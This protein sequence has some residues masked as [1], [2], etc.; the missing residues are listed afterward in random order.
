[1]I[2]VMII[3]AHVKIFPP[4]VRS[5]PGAYFQR[6]MTFR[7]LYANADAPMVGPEELLES[8]D[9]NKIQRACLVNI[10]WRLP[11]LSRESND[12]LLEV[13]MAHP[14]RLVAFCSVNPLAGEEAVAEVHR[15]AALGARGVGELHPDTQG[16]DLG[17]AE[18]MRPVMAA[19]AE[20][21][22]VVL[23]HASEP[24]GHVYP[25]KGQVTPGTL[26]RFVTN[27]PEARVILAHWGGGLPFYALMPEVRKALR[28]VSFD[29][30]ASP[31]LYDPR[32][33]ETVVRLVGAD[34]ILFAT[35]Y[36]L[37]QPERLLKQVE[38]AALS[39]EEK[40]L[41]TGGNAAR[42]LGLA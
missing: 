25:G 1:M 34:K 16:F 21:D 29:T 19:A 26:Y 15:C 41:I 27:F 20:H 42:L 30:A 22:M 40:A 31:F 13:A 11:D 39:P 23:T 17:D 24:V 9:R 32:I 14:A 3:D 8:M 5:N 35:D 10:G 6:D 18:I 4:S 28:N 36:P 2:P 37:I 33:F 7:T 12:Y 38:A